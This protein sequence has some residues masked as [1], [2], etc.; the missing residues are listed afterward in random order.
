MGYQIKNLL[1]KS[2]SIISNE[3]V[4][5]FLQRT[6]LF[7]KTKIKARW[8]RFRQK[9]YLEEKIKSSR[10]VLVSFVIPV[11][12]RTFELKEAIE[13]CLNQTVSEI[14]VII[15]TDG[16]P[17]DTLAVLDK[18]SH[19]PKVKIFHYYDN[20]GNAVRGRNKGIL[21][22]TGKYIAFLDSDDIADKNRIKK[23]LN[24]MERYNADVVYGAYKIKMDN[25]REI[26]GLHDGRVIESPDCDLQFLKEI[27]VPCQS[28][29][30]I[31]RAA[32]LDVGGLKPEMCYCED[33]ELWL[34]LAYFGY[35]FKA[36]RDVLVTLRIHK[37]NNELN[38]IEE[39]DYWKQEALRQYQTRAK[40]LQK[41]VFIIPGTGIS[42]GIAVVL[43]HA[44]KL[45]EQKFDVSCI[46]LDVTFGNSINWFPEHNVPIYQLSNLD[47]RVDNIDVAIATGWNT[48]EILNQL[49]P[50]RKLY[51]VQSD[52]RRFY[53]DEATKKLVH[54]T[55]LTDCEYVTMACWIQKWLKDEFGH[56]S[57]YVPNG[58]DQNMFFHDQ[59]ILPKEKKV[60]VLL[61]GPVDIPFKGMKEAYAAVKDLNCELWI[62][63]SS[64]K[65]PAE[66]KYDRLFE[67]VDIHKMR[68]IY[69]SCDIFLK[70]SRVESFCYP[71]LEAMACGCSVV[72]SEVTGLEEYAIDNY[73]SLIVKPGDVAEAKMAVRTLIENVELRHQLIEN[74]YKTAEEWTWSDSKRTFAKILKAEEEQLELQAYSA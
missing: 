54:Q 23:S 43:H 14:E 45:M 26:N 63:S 29:V 18:Y 8:D 3:G 51:F 12:D 32:L 31:R 22:A 60:R 47:M 9:S 33:Y 7:L 20:S 24:V 35:K 52:E 61:E 74:G 41:I 38:F 30:M 39:S 27:C 10:R 62:I 40:K 1:S 71:P 48:V 70:M 17:P 59:E 19:H 37:G 58:L 16:S 21:E 5:A 72:V 2:V 50:K 66:W 69:S 4:L 65:I 6:C 34:R 15:V 68:N 56:D 49:E 44:K 11:Y 57:E 67:K 36:T 28:T 64:G 73:N 53:T 13:S 42:G 55:Y 25:S 46:N